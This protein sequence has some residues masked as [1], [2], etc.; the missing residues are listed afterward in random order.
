MTRTRFEPNVQYVFCPSL[1][2]LPPRFAGWF[3]LVPAAALIALELAAWALFTLHT[4][5]VAP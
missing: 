2:G 4:T 1:S 3:V 5:T